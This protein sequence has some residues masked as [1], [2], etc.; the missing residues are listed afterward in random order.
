[1][2][3]RTAGAALLL[4]TLALALPVACVPESTLLPA[5]AAVDGSAQ[6]SGDAAAPEAGDDRGDAAAGPAS[7]RLAVANA[8]GAGAVLA[9]LHLGN[10]WFI[11]GDF[12][13]V[14]TVITPNM[15]GVDAT[16]SAPV[17]CPLDGAFNGEV[18]AIAATSSAVYVGGA[19]TSYRGA[20]ASRLAKIDPATCALDAPFSFSGGFNDTVSALAVDGNDLYVGGAF[21]SYRGVAGN[22]NRIAKLHATTG[23][24]SPAF[25]PTA[26][27][28]FDLDV[29]ALALTATHVYVGGAF[30]R[31]K[32][33]AGSANRIA[34]LDRAD[35]GI[36][37]VFSPA[38]GNGFQDGVV[39]AIA[40]TGADVF[41]GGSFTQYRGAA[42]SAN[43]IA[44]LNPTT[45]VLDGTFSP[46]PNGFDAPVRALAV[47]GASLYVGGT[48]TA[49]RGIASSARRIAKL[50]RS[51]GSI[52]VVFNN[53]NNGFDDAVDAIVA[54]DSALWVGGRFGAYG[55][56]LAPAARVAKLTLDGTRTP[57]FTPPGQNAG[58]VAGTTVRALA[59]SGDTVWLGGSFTC[60]GGFEAR[61]LAK[62]DDATLAVDTQFNAAGAGGFDAPVS[63]IAGVGDVLFVGG[64]FAFYR[65]AAANHLAKLDAKNGALDTL[66]SPPA[67]NGFS[68][69]GGGTGGGVRALALASDVLYVG[70][71]FTQYR[72]IESSANNIAVLNPSSGA[73]GTIFGAAGGSNGFSAPVNA[74]AFD[75]TSLYVG[76][77]FTTYKAGLEAA[78]GV[79]KVSRTSGDIDTKFSP[80][81]ANANGFTGGPVT[82]L[83]LGPGGLHVGGAFTAY[84]G[85]A[86]S[87]NGIAK[88]DPATGEIDKAFATVNGGFDKP[89]LSLA[90]AGPDLWVGGRFT[91]YRGPSSPANLVAKLNAASGA[92]DT[93][94]SPGAPQPNGFDGTSVDTLALGTTR[95]DAGAC[96]R[97]LSGGAFATYRGEL[98]GRGVVILDPASGGRR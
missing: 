32:G 62:L 75:A 22:A 37:A 3:A 30:T 68:G 88:L 70:G 45:G 29:S 61:G 59:V 9:S 55:A 34:K 72:G 92:L 94:F 12:E 51:T 85:V 14:A 46:A 1:M 24:L 58:G 4:S 8:T 5:D 19:F 33:I 43:R 89:V 7:P 65:G 63:A 53:A 71:D 78:L 13:R 48:F 82:S 98:V 90:A 64:R 52:D 76:G 84:R 95:C 87:A 80:P 60:Y 15:V 91:Q 47:G 31:Y 77:E 66:F 10:A 41:A 36:D 54:T 74:F 86:A 38:T 97:L 20:P 16:T 17:K 27:N 69:G 79:A 83:A 49:Y 50:S 73:I 67:S 23:V 18:Q 40:V 21:T 2:E 96:P 39:S 11:G 44:K 26:N 81:G 56:L 6:P 93:T 35:G 28:G 42:G 57:S 25:N